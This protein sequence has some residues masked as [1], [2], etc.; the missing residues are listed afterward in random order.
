MG[1]ACEKFVS[2]YPFFRIHHSLREMS[3]PTHALDLMTLCW[4]HDPA[5]RPSAEEICAIASSPEFAHLAE[6]TPLDAGEWTQTSPDAQVE[7]RVT[8]ALAVT[9]PQEEADRDGGTS[10]LVVSH[11]SIRGCV[12]PSVRRS[13]GPSVGPSVDYIYF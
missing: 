11:D 9:A 7:R 6:A 13:V 2:F 12:R 10:F 4:A 3:Y 1:K 5:D 8:H